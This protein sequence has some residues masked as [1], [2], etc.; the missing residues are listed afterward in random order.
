[1]LAVGQD[2]FQ[3]K[4]LERNFYVLSD[5][6]LRPSLNAWQNWL[7]L[8]GFASAIIASAFNLLPLLQGLLVLLGA[9]IASR[10]LKASELRR[11]FPFELWVIIA[12]ALTISLAMQNT[13]ASVLL[14]ESIYA[15]FVGFGVMGALIGVYLLTWLL[16]ELITNTAAA[17]IAFPIALA[18]AEAFGASYI[19]FVMVVAYAASANFFLPF[20]Y[21]THLMVFSPGQYQVKDYMKVGWAVWLVYTATVLMLVPLVFE[22]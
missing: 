2:F 5:E 4:N 8:G 14:S 1:M 3:H 18:S 7:V 10:I 19:P 11:R 6:P 13:G 16:T 20:G 9:L 17:A 22:F 12:S 21:Q 15:L